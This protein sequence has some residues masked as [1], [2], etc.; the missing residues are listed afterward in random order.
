MR[1]VKHVQWRPDAAPMTHQHSILAENN[2]LSVPKTHISAANVF[3]GLNCWHLD[4]RRPAGLLH[5]D[6]LHRQKRSSSVGRTDLPLRADIASHRHVRFFPRYGHFFEL[7][8]PD[9]PR[10]SHLTPFL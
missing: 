2:K 3:L 5:I 6:L 10:L 9:R 1:L 7:N 4:W 8:L